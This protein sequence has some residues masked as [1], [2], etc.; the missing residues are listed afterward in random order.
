MSNLVLKHHLHWV[1]NA[2]LFPWS[3]PETRRWA[4]PTLQHPCEGIMLGCNQGRVQQRYLCGKVVKL[5]VCVHEVMGLNL[6][7]DVWFTRTFFWDVWGSL[8]TEFMPRAIISAVRE[9]KYI[10]RN[11]KYNVVDHIILLLLRYGKGI[12]LMLYLLDV[13]VF[14]LKH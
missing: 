5:L 6:G 14:R 10:W 13:S 4:R 7:C 11:P 9:T 3:T 12:C 8:Y 1:C 2:E